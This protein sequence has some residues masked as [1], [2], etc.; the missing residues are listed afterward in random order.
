V[1]VSGS[2]SILSRIFS[3]FSDAVVTKPSNNNIIAAKA[4]NSIPEEE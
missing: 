2:F 1:V 3:V 4:Q